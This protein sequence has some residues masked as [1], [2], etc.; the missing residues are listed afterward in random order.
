MRTYVV[1]FSTDSSFSIWLLSKG[2][3]RILESESLTLWSAL[4]NQ[5]PDTV[6]RDLVGRGCVRIF[7]QCFVM[8]TS[9]AFLRREAIHLLFSKISGDTYSL[10]ITPHLNQACYDVLHRTA[11]KYCQPV[12]RVLDFGCGPGT[13]LD[14]SF[15]NV[16]ILIGFDF[17]PI[18][19]SIANE[20]GL[21]VVDSHELKRKEHCFDVVVCCYVLHYMSVSIE[22]ISIVFDQIR[23][24]GVWV[25]NFHKDIGVG[26]FLESIPKNVHVEIDFIPSAFG[27]LVCAKKVG[28]NEGV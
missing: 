2:F 16:D 3:V 28:V 20:K 22:M 23:I 21:H 6:E 11:I 26:W 7:E 4:M 19:R 15:Q 10:V 17:I 25:A 1:S 5:K 24:G 13:V 27:V 8:Q 18:N 9:D 12:Q 14:S